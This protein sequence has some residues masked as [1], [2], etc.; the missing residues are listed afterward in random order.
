MTEKRSY[1]YIALYV[2]FIAFALIALMTTSSAFSATVYKSVDENGLTTY[3]DVKPGD[4]AEVET[5]EIAVAE[6]AT[7]AEN[8]QRLNDMRETTDRMA[9]DR[10]AREKHRAEL[11]K[12][13]TQRALA[14]AQADPSVA[15]TYP[16]YPTYQQPYSRYPYWQP[17][18]SPVRHHRQRV[19]PPLR[20]RPTLSNLPRTNQY[21]ASLVRRHYPPAVQEALRR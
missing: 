10:M 4:A 2:V 1:P 15:P 18:Y 21:P 12:L 8:Q 13:E 5:L 9:S 7:E 16:I 17:D 14:N 6:P 19:T 20:H 11:K 3:S